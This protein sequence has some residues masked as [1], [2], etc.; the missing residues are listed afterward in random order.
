MVF[1]FA[2]RGVLKA[3]FIWVRIFSRFDRNRVFNVYRVCLVSMFEIDFRGFIVIHETGINTVDCVY[4]SICYRLVAQYLAKNR[5][6]AHQICNLSSFPPVPDMSDTIKRTG[7]G[8]FRRGPHLFF[9]RLNWL[10]PHPASPLSLQAVD[11][12]SKVAVSPI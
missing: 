10:H 8:Y 9:C 6:I 7:K 11:I 4:T 2:N 3:C 1:T 12:I 5:H